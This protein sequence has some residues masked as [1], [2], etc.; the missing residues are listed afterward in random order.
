VV[1]VDRLGDEIESAELTGTAS[2]LISRDDRHGVT[3]L[4]PPRRNP[5]SSAC[6]SVS[7]LTGFLSTLTSVFDN[8]WRRGSKVSPD[9]MMAVAAGQR[10]RTLSMTSSPLRVGNR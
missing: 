5:L 7:R 10:C 8:A 3:D 1:K 4:A 2:S 9:N 6:A